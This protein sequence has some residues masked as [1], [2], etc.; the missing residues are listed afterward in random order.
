LIAFVINHPDFPRP[1]A[2]IGADK[3][4]IDT[5]LRQLAGQLSKM[6]NYS[7][8][9][10]IDPKLPAAPAVWRVFDI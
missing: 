2:I 10:F 5:I 4:F 8:G 3:A 1:N 6:Q 9:I 7:M